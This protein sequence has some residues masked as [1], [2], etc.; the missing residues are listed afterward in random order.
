MKKL[1]ALLSTF[2]LTLAIVGLSTKAPQAYADSEKWTEDPTLAEDEIPM[3][4]MGSI[5]TTFPNHYD[6]AA[7]ADEAWG[8]A[9]RMYPWNETRLRVAEYDANG[10]ATG[11]YY[12]VFFSGL[13]SHLDSSGAPQS[14]AGYNVNGYAYKEDGTI[15]TVRV[16]PNN[17]GYTYDAT[18]ADPSLSHLRL[19]FTGEDIAIDMIEVSNAIGD[20]SNKH[21]MYNRMIVFDGEGRIIRGIA[22]DSF[23]QKPGTEGGIA[24]VWA[25][26]FCYVNDELVKYVE[27][28][29]VCDK[30]K[31]EVKDDEGNKVYDEDGNPKY[32]V[33]DEDNFLYKRFMWEWFEEKPENVNTASYLAEGWDCDLWDYCF[34][35]DGG[36]MAIAF[37]NAAGTNHLVK[38]VEVEVTNATRAAAGKEPLEDNHFRA[39]VK[40]IRVPANGGTYDFGY[41]DNGVPAE[42]TKFNNIVRGSYLSG[43][44]VGSAEPRTYNFSSKPLTTV[45]MVIDGYSYQLMEG[46][47][48]IEVIKGQTITPAK[49]ISYTGMA[50]AWLVENDFT[51][52]A[53]DL[54]ALEY[55]LYVD[56]AMVVY[57][58]N[59]YSKEEMVADFLNDVTTFMEEARG[60][61]TFGHGEGKRAVTLDDLYPFNADGLNWEL[62]SQSQKDD[63]F[64]G[65]AEMRAKWS[66]LL[67]YV[68]QVRE[69]SG[70]SNANFLDGSKGYTPSPG[71]F[72]CEIANFLANKHRTSWPASSDY[73]VGEGE[74]E[75]SVKNATGFL[76]EKSNQE[77]F[78]EYSID[79]TEARIDQTYEVKFVV[80]NAGGLESS[81]TINY[82]VVDEYTPI[83]EVDKN[84]LYIQ[85]SFVAGKL[86][87]DPIDLYDIAT[88]Y[89]G[90]YN[91]SNIKGDDI[92]DD[93]HF[94][95][96]TLDLAHP[97]EGSH[98]VT[99][100]VANNAR[101]YA[102]KTFTIVITDLTA[103]QAEFYSELVLPYGTTWDPKLAVKSAYDMVDGNL[104]QAS[105]VWCVSDKAVKTQ[106]PGEY[107]VVV[108]V[109]DKSGNSVDS[110]KMTVTVLEKNVTVADLEAALQ[111]AGIT[112]KLE[113]IEL[114]LIDLQ[115]AVNNLPQ[116][117]DIQ[118]ILD[119][120]AA[121]E[122]PGKKVEAAACATSSAA[123]VFQ[124]LAAGCL[125]VFLLRKKH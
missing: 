67:G 79:T 90:R 3:Y 37:L 61:A 100:Y 57:R 101:H 38:D 26:Q 16:K 25:P 36:W 24:D 93:M 89:N 115:D 54:N 44:N 75:Q 11:K 40:E 116:D 73:T 49:N 76:P 62:I 53:R 77:S 99:A 43:R 124:F 113:G 29:T 17:Q 14:G 110:K 5:Y 95:H 6:N 10:A 47:N 65:N 42:V 102:E 69:A 78:L 70:L 120:I 88:A 72:N 87:V 80:K 50:S 30:V 82:K 33:T 114:S 59:Y 35:A 20:G 58:F 28:E 98:V 18:P 23:Y 103:P 107:R 118:A 7:K 94:E 51:S 104:Q 123:S 32:E 21:T 92:S 41:L 108:S 55:T 86:T 56:G 45:D 12:A 2:V 112:A 121:I 60:H 106:N 109:Y 63:C 74:T 68:M 13:T 66:W 122:A 1:F 97:T 22:A 48:T 27:G 91:G 125:L 105:F 83:I 85:P 119:A 46:K 19:N 4:E 9:T 39:C 84:K 71:T 81:Y 15:T 117:T 52:Y 34:E 64:W 96:P 31:V 8:G 111:D